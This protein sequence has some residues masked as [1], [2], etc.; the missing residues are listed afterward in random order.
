M[1]VDL[2]LFFIFSSALSV[3]DLSWLGMYLKSWLIMIF[4]LVNLIEYDGEL[5]RSNS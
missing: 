3:F 2:V 4:S 1:I 5:N